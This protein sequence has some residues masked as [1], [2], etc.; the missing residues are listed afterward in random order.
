M[1]IVKN[2]EERLQ[3]INSR[4]NRWGNRPATTE[5]L[6]NL[7]QVAQSTIK[8]DIAY[9]KEVHE[10]PIEYSRKP[11]GYYY[12][13][14][15]NLAASITLTDKD[16]TALHAAVATLNQYQHL[17]LFDDLRGTVDKIDKAVRFR[18]NAVD[19]YGQ[20]ILFESVPFVKG[21]EWVDVF[22]RAIHARCVVEFAHQRF[23]TE[24][25]KM[26]RLFPYV[27]KEHRNRW[28]VVGWQLDYQSIRV[29]GLDRIVDGSVQI[30]H[31]SYDAPEFDANIYFHQALG[32]AAYDNPPEEVILSFTR[33][34][35]LIF[36]AQPFY[37]F[38]EEDVLVDSEHE[39]RVKLSIIVNKELVYELARLGNSVNVIS[40]PSL[41]QELSE[42]H[43]SAWQ[44][45]A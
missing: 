22:L 11:K 23:D 27:I 10:A 32:V 29:F 2:R 40:P 42:F 24:K 41:V 18:T 38:Q 28:Y 30:T 3:A 35:G 1:P 6:A 17:H 25:T 36:R 14:P 13:R 20:Y 33:Q 5:E 43:K 26:H 16:L 4:L 8:Q 12:T 34:Q 31:E 21:S 39:L 44:Q 37:P 15:F 19:D 9:L 7:C 45:Y